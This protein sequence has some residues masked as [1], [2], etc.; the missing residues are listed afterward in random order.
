VIR[1]S[2]RSHARATWPPVVWC[3]PRRPTPFCLWIALS[4]V[5][6]WAA[7]V[8]HLSRLVTFSRVKAPRDPQFC[9][10][11]CSSS[12]F[13]AKSTTEASRQTWSPTPPTY[14]S[15][16]TAARKNYILISLPFIFFYLPLLIVSPSV[17]SAQKSQPWWRHFLLSLGGW[18]HLAGE[19]PSQLLFRCQNATAQ[20]N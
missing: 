5:F 4:L 19:L 9:Y 17:L 2:V 6:K 12:L 11:N 13:A 20:R 16:L 15:R 8:E 18:S 7:P 1:T 3:R 10:L 14:L